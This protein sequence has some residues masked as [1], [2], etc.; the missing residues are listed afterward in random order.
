MM[1][2]ICRFTILIF[3]GGEIDT[4]GIKNA[5]YDCLQCLFSV[6]KDAELSQ[7]PMYIR[8]LEILYTPI[9]VKVLML[10]KYA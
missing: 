2:N 6:L 9:G 5:Y 8:M 4:C 3:P 7:M 1:A 10:L